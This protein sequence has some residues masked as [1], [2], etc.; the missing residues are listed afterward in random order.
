[1]PRQADS[2]FVG[3]AGAAN[4]PSAC[5]KPQAAVCNPVPFR[6]F[7]AIQ[8]FL[9]RGLAAIAITGR[10]RTTISLGRESG[11]TR[12]G[13]LQS[14]PAVPGTARDTPPA[15]GDRNRKLVSVFT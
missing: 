1:M 5:L 3:D 13:A 4:T 15:I 10:R 2:A 11:G 12:Q 14:T 9:F 7:A 8:S 6:I